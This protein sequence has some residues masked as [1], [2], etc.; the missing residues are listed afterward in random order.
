MS[1]AAGVQPILDYYRLYDIDRNWKAKE[2][3]NI[4]RK[5]QAD[6]R[7]QMAALQGRDEET[8]KK[9]RKYL[10]KLLRP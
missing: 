7:T 8:L 1:A 5:K 10:I 9:F 4:I 2:I 3:V 6:A